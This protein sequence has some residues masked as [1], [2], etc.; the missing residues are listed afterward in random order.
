VE[1]REPSFDADELDLLI[2]EALVREPRISFKELATR[3]RVDQRTVAKRVNVLTA[4]EVLRQ[5]VEID[6]S[7]LGLQATAYVGSTTARGADYARKLG[8]LIKNDPR[9]VE[10]FET[11]GTYQHLVKVIDND[12]SKMRD[13]VIR[14]L[15]Q[16]ASDLTPSLVTKRLKYDYGAL[17]RYLRESRYPRSRSRSELISNQKAVRGDSKIH[18]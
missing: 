8:E 12:A 2:L 11:L 10:T 13:T 3:L 4:K 16:L 7:K 15:D 6:W 18:I 9:I 5:T 1:S 17:I 14:D